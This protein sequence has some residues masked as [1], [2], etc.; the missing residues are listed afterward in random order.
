MAKLGMGVFIIVIVPFKL[1]SL[2]PR[3]F[4]RTKTN[5]TKTKKGRT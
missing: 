4:A 5:K 2:V 1:R 3:V